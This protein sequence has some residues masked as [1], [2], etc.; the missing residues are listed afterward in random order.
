[1]QH[2]ISVI[3]VFRIRLLAV[4]VVCTLLLTN[5]PAALAHP[6][7]SV[8]HDYIVSLTPTTLT[9]ESYLRVSPELVPQV[10]RTIDTNG[11]GQTSQSESEAWFQAHPATLGLTLD[12]TAL[13]PSISQAPSIS[14]S[15]LIQSIDHPIK[16]VYTATWSEPIAGKH[17]IQITY[18]DNY[19]DFDE[20]F[21]SVADDTAN[22]SEPQS[23]SRNKYPATFQIVYH[24]PTTEEASNVPQG[25]MAPPPYYQG[26][27]T[28][29]PATPSAMA[30]ATPSLAPVS[31]SD[32]S[33]GSAVTGILDSLRNWHG[34]L[35]AGLDLA[36]LAL[37]IGAL[38]ALTPG[39]G[40]TMVA[41][42]LIGS[43]GRVRDAVLL[44]GVVTFTHTIGVVVLG[45]ILLLV[46]TFTVPRN[47][48]PIL[49]LSAGVLVLLL[50]GY[51]LFT[52]WRD[53]QSGR[54]AP[55]VAQ[56]SPVARQSRV[57][58]VDSGSSVAKA[59]KI[60][61]LSP[62]TQTF[63]TAGSLEQPHHHSDHDTHTHAHAHDGHTHTH[64]GHTHSHAL[65]DRLSRG[66]L[67]GLGVSGGL[68]PCPDALAILLLATSVGQ[69]ALGLGLVISFSIGLAAVLIAIGVVLVSARGALE[70]SRAASFTQSS[71]WT[72]WV[73]L[74]SAAAVVTIGLVMAL[75]AL[76]NFR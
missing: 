19:L 11:D 74:A 8:L 72:R 1:M 29:L 31:G 43:R 30:T 55:A 4:L 58:A 60:T 38:H 64:D 70:R 50:G 49:E 76:N 36:M 33:S 41:A 56:P 51:L 34:E 10:Y 35:W 2:V 44:G 40:K 24:I 65:P 47:L 63:A 21:I 7:P 27:P 68:V 52:R 57:F 54:T 28:A 62:A 45:L 59:I 61:K 13:Q 18:G 26:A 3:R 73:P 16:V 20:Y 69:F 39:H 37:L 9:V 71:F 15:D 5:A 25:E 23:V 67:I 75:T 46:S 48:Q 6:A 32:S 42:Y 14:L 17:R 22:D 12:G 66:S 53:A